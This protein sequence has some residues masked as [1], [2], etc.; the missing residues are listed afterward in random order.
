MVLQRARLE[1]CTME[2]GPERPRRTCP[3]IVFFFISPGPL[4]TH[5]T[6]EVWNRECGGERTDFLDLLRLMASQLLL[7]H[8]EAPPGRCFASCY[9]SRPAHAE[10]GFCS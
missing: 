8:T 10:R 7:A 6:M 9:E 3:S 2:E 4:D 5:H 1:R